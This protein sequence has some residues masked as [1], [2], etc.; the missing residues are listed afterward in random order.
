ML[1]GLYLNKPA[2]GRA[3]DDYNPLCIL[4]PVGRRP[5]AVTVELRAKK[6]D[7]VYLPLGD[8][9]TGQA[10]EKRNKNQ[11]ERLLA[12]KMLEE[13]NRADGLD[14]PEGELILARAMLGVRARRRRKENK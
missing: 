14:P 13:L 3:G 8:E 7:C 12:L 1:R 9:P 11:I 10:W 4:N 6:R 2:D 5:Y